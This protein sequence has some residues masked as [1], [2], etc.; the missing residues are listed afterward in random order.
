MIQKPKSSLFCQAFSVSGKWKKEPETANLF[1]VYTIKEIRIRLKR[2]HLSIQDFPV[3]PY[4]TVISLHQCAVNKSLSLLVTKMKVSII[5]VRCLRYRSVLPWTFQF[6]H[7]MP[8]SAITGR[9]YSI[10]NYCPVSCMK[11]DQVHSFSG[12]WLFFFLLFFFFFKYSCFL[13][14]GLV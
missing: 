3:P 14:F 7:V 4:S 12:R 1:G 9:Y 10:V 5:S 6:C 11:L 2:Y 13:W 8:Y